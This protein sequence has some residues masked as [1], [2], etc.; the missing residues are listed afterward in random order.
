[1]NS[2]CV[3]EISKFEVGTKDFEVIFDELKGGGRLDE[4]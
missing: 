4:F 2:S 1:L 3:G